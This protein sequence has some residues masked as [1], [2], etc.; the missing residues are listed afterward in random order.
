MAIHAN[1]IIPQQ[2]TTP[3]RITVENKNFSELRE[4]A[5]SLSQ[6]NQEK[7]TKIENRINSKKTSRYLEDLIKKGD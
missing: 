7:Q 2:N 4:L 6:A 5:V 3:E 1:I